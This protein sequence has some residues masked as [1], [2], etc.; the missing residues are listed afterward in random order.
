MPTTPDGRERLNGGA[1]PT[2][3]Q[4]GVAAIHNPKFWLEKFS[5]IIVSARLSAGKA[6]S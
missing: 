3:K 2:P 4:V 5:G 6:E 1:M